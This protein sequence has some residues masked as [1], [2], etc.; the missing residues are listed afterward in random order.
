MLAS[1]KLQGFTQEELE[2]VLDRIDRDR[3]D[4]KADNLT[5]VNFRT[6]IANW[7]LWVY[8]LM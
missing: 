1:N 4:S 5:W 7:E 3:G 6:H 8:G 2:L